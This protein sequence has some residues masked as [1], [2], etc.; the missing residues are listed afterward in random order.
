[1]NKSISSRYFRTTAFLLVTSITFLGVVLMYFCVG[2]FRAE[3]EKTLLT[4]VRSL[5]DNFS[6]ISVEKLDK[7]RSAPNVAQAVGV[8]ANE[9]GRIFLLRDN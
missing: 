5:R 7:L 1:M 4:S 6:T 2:Y 9:T 8:V 3:S